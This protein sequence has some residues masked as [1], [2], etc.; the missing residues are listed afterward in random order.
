MNRRTK[1]KVSERIENS[2]YLSAACEIRRQYSWWKNLGF[3][4]LAIAEH[5]WT[6][7]ILERVYAKEI[8]VSVYF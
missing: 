6:E 2:G 4:S 3:L 5:S 1:Y 7:R 8:A